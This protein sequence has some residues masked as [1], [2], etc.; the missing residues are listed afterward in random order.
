[1]SRFMICATDNFVEDRN[2][3]FKAKIIKNFVISAPGL[4]RVI[5]D[6]LN[7]DVS[8]IAVGDDDKSKKLEVAALRDRIRQNEMDI[9]CIGV[10]ERM[11]KTEATILD[12]MAANIDRKPKPV[13]RRD[14]KPLPKPIKRNAQSVIRFVAPGN[15]MAKALMAANLVQM[16]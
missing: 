8:D 12:K 1:M 6:H 13:L 9:A 7:V 3:A 11:V 14:R 15:T 5:A 10:A 4:Y 16:V 2:N